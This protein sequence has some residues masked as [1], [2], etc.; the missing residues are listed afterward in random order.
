MSPVFTIPHLTAD[1]SIFRRGEWTY[2]LENLRI[3]KS[4]N[5]CE[6]YLFEPD[7]SC[8]EKVGYNLN[9]P[10]YVLIGFVSKEVFPFLGP[11]GAV[12]FFSCAHMEFCV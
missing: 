3:A 5:A 2:C 1:N 4:L 11:L 6:L 10:L 9:N 8:E 12:V 7:F